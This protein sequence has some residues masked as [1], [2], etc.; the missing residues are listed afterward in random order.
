MFTWK[1]MTWL[2]IDP[3]VI[4]KEIMSWLFKDPIVTVAYL[5]FN[6]VQS[7]SRK[8]PKMIKLPQMNFILKK[9]LKNFSCTYEHLSFCKILKQFLEPIQSYEDVPFLGSK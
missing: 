2:F 1:I 9:Q 7:N 3:V 8:R 5:T 6:R 4:M